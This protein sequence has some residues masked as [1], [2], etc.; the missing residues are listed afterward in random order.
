MNKEDTKIKKAVGSLLSAWGTEMLGKVPVIDGGTNVD[1]VK[2]AKMKETKALIETLK[3]LGV[4]NSS[5]LFEL[6]FLAAGMMI[7]F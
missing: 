2:F 3:H 6:G 5:H 7:Q 4:R 1:M